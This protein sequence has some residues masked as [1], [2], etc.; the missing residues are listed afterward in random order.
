MV[1]VIL[2]ISH[3]NS[4]NPFYTKSIQN[5]MPALLY[6]SASLCFLAVTTVVPESI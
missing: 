6:N 4:K 5:P 3:C 2:A 1:N